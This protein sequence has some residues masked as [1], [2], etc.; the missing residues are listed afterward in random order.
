MPDRA[1]FFGPFPSYS[2]SIYLR[3]L[4]KCGLAE[5]LDGIFQSGGADDPLGVCFKWPFQRMPLPSQHNCWCFPILGRQSCSKMW[6]ISQS[7]EASSR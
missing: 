2:V 1:A 5:A 6:N 3:S 7:W 4:E